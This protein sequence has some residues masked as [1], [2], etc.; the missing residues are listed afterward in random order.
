M[1]AVQLGF[2]DYIDTYSSLN[3]DIGRT[4]YI[5]VIENINF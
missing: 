4:P 3:D 1:P 2:C 5:N